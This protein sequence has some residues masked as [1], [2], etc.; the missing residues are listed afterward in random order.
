MDQINVLMEEFNVWLYPQNKKFID[1]ILQ[2][3]I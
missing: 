1:A 2:T 3:K